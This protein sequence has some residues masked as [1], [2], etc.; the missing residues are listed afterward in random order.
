MYIYRPDNG[1]LSADIQVPEYFKASRFA[2]DWIDSII[3]VDVDDAYIVARIKEAGSL[4]VLFDSS[5]SGGSSVTAFNGRTGAIIPDKG[6]YLPFYL[7]KIDNVIPINS[8]ADFPTQDGSTI[9][10]GGPG[11]LGKAYVFGADVTT[12]KN[13]NVVGSC[14]IKSETVFTKF[15]FSGVGDFITF[16]DC[17]VEIEDIS[18]SSPNR[19]AIKG[20]STGSYVIDHRVNLSNCFI[21]DCSQAYVSDG[22]GIITNT[23]QVQNVTGDAVDFLAGD[24]GICSLNQ[25]GVFGLTAGSSLVKVDPLNTFFVI[26]EMTDTAGFGDTAATFMDFGANSINILPGSVAVIAGCNAQSF[27]TPL[28]GV[29][30][31]DDAFE[32]RANT[33]IPN[34]LICGSAYLSALTTV[35]VADPD[36]FYKIN[37]NNWTKVKGCRLTVTDDGDFINN[38]SRS[39]DI[40]IDGFVTV[41]KVGGGQ[42]LVKA[43]IVYDDNPSDP[44]SIAT[45]NQTENTQPTSIPLTGLFTLEPQKGVSI[46][47]ANAQT[48]DILVYKASFSTL[49]PI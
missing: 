7:E 1:D 47:V 22:T 15:E 43:R 23:L 4:E 3:T 34:S 30:I 44:Q 5:T 49:E 40:K 27:T 25:F 48:S 46:W 17:F 38:T 31:D 20:V 9:T 33:G 42:D 45:E 10:L 41:E 2:P 11:E 37:Q 32:F 18:I 26:L 8:E 13:V 12:A 39:M 28:V 21:L 6:D 35:A 16:T 19:V 14:V 24:V 36:T 29:T